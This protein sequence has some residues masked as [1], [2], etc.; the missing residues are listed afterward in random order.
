MIGPFLLSI[1]VF[2]FFSFLHYSFLFP[3]VRK[4]KLSIRQLLDARNYSVSYRIVL[5]V[6]NLHRRVYCFGRRSSIIR[7]VADVICDVIESRDV[8]G[9]SAA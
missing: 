9:E 5:K 4:I 8:C 1:S 7:R 3:L 2:V 6:V